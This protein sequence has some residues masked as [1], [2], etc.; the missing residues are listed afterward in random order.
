MKKYF[1]VLKI[2]FISAILVFAIGCAT[3]SG[4]G[5]SGTQTGGNTNNSG[6]SN[7]N[8]NSNA[9]NNNDNGNSGNSSNDNNNN[10]GSNDNNGGNSGNDNNGGNATVILVSSIEIS[11][12]A[13]IAKGGSMTLTKSVKPLDAA[14][15]A[16]LWNSSNEDVAK[17]D[18][19]GKVTGYSVGSTTI[20]A[21]A[22]DGSGVVSNSFD[23][24]VIDNSA[25]QGAITIN[26][27]KGS[28]ESA[29]VEWTPESSCDGYNVYIQK[30]GDSSW[31]KLDS[32]LVRSYAASA[33]STTVDHWRADALGLSSGTYQF[34]VVGTL[35]GTETGAQSVSAIASVENYD[36]SGFAFTGATTPG[37]YKAD[38]TLKDGAIVM[39]V[40]K[41]NAKTI[42]YE[43]TRGGG[44]K[45]S[46]GLQGILSESY[47]K[48]MTVPLCIRIVGTITSEDFPQSMWGSNKEG[49]Q[50]KN[51]SDKGITIEGI[52]N[53]ATFWGFGI[54][55]RDSKYVELR[56][57]AVMCF[58][59]DGVSL[60]T[61]N[62]YSWVHNMDF[63]YG[64]VGGD[65][66]QA[67]G[68]GSLDVKGDSK[69]QTYSYNH[70]WDSGKMSLCGMKSESGPNYI[71]YHHNWFDHSDS[72]HPRVR[73]M[74]VHVY[75]NYYDGN[76]KYGAG[77][78]TGSNLFVE[79]N[80]FRNCKFP[81]LSSMQ[82][83]DIY[84]GTPAQSNDYATFSKEAGGFIK[85]YNN[86]IV[87]TINV[88]SYWPYSGTGT[89]ITKGAV[90]S[91]PSGID[92]K[93]QFDAYEV[94][95][96]SEKVPD[97]AVTVNGGFKY[98]NFDTSVNLGVS[99]SDIDEPEVAKEK[100]ILNAGRLYGG[101]FEWTFK[102]SD[103]TSYDV[104][105]ALKAKVVGYKSKMIAVQGGTSNSGSENPGSGEQG[106]SGSSGGT[107]EQGGSGQGSGSGSG[108]QG[109][110]AGTIIT[111]TGSGTASSSAVTG[112]W[113]I[114]K[115]KS[116]TYN[117]VTYGHCVNME[118]STE[119][120]I[121]LAAESNVT[122]V[123][124]T[125]GKNIKIDN[126][127]HVTGED[128]TVTQTLT[129][130]LHTITK[131]DKLLVGCIII[132]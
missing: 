120:K 87:D 115:G 125:A 51:T 105:T 117:G 124:D 103:D 112:S 64:S 44:S 68:D 99:E 11:G 28:F 116:I 42:T 110:T 22:T 39:Y 50:V 12:N 46:E 88:T 20:T 36:R 16:L 111:F 40:H 23:L 107:G 89:N 52:G 9:G 98:S 80:Y 49:L 4:G 121:N 19:T 48:K 67:K 61:N 92:T 129:A 58:A 25:I 21:T 66:D 18:A 123:T 56:N 62:L 3:D 126:T 84:A 91:I 86:K 72:R 101:D 119:I 113:K 13:T 45:T 82:G 93:V 38:G 77:A 78:T 96:R 131:G 95:S 81:M 32:P 114:K 41:D 1:D 55:C 70:F 90:G 15:K 76:A 37:A 128:C 100:V 118:S 60:D 97:D 102:D 5:G 35:S 10:G 6:N 73:S 74:S 65:A 130:G 108:E 106:G 75:N 27:V 57:F 29:Y 26:S 54:L 85:A 17:V 43:T 2:F 59:D 30:S 34:K 47:L 109:A 53:D 71:T 14:N 104:D 33:G 24:S 94:S 7:T 69:Y 63:F 83:N 122:I 127:S 31:T 79:G 8:N 132:N